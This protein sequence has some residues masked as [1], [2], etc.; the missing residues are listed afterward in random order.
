MSIKL[1]IIYI[2]IYIYT[3]IY[4]NYSELYLL[5]YACL[6]AGR[7]GH[8]PKTATVFR[9]WPSSPSLSW[10]KPSLV[11]LS[12]SL[13][14]VSWTT[15]PLPRGLHLVAWLVMVSWD[16]PSVWSIDLHFLFFISFAMGSCLVHF[17]SVVLDTLSDHFTCEILCRPLLMK[18]CSTVCI[19]F[20]F[21]HDIT[22]T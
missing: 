8:R 4:I 17:Q 7:T 20:Y 11:S 12:V 13:P 14:G 2:Y 19:V 22:Y 5:T 3:Y 1:H 15:S 16:F 18:V 9:P 6:L 21:M 10:C